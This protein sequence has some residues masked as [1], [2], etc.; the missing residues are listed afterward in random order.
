[1]VKLRKGVKRGLTIA[2]S[3]AMVVQGTQY[4]V[5][6]NAYKV[7]AAETAY[8]TCGFDNYTGAVS[9]ND[10]MMLAGEAAFTS[11]T[12]WGTDS[13]GF[14][15][16]TDNL[17]AITLEK[18]ATMKVDVILPADAAFQ[19][20]LKVQGVAQIGDS[21]VWTQCDLIPE[22]T[23]D[24]FT[25]MGDGYCKATVTFPFSQAT[26]YGADEAVSYADY[27][28][29]QNI[30]KV[31]LNFIG[32]ACDLNS[33]LYID[34]L[35]FS[36]EVTQ[37][38]D[39][40]FTYNFDGYDGAS[41]VAGD[42]ALSA[43]AAFTS[44]T[45]WGVDQISHELSTP[46]AGVTL[47]KGSDYTFDVIVPA[48]AAFEGVI[49]AQG[50]FKLGDS[51]MWTQCDVIPEL[52]WSS[53]T[54]MGNG[55]CKATVTFPFSQATCYGADGSC[56][57]ADYDGSMEIKSAVINLIGYACNLNGTVAIDNLA[58]TAESQPEVP[59]VEDF[60]LTMDDVSGFTAG[61]TSDAYCYTGTISL[62][63]RTIDGN[64]LLGV[65]LDYR[66]NV[67]ESWSEPKIFYNFSSPLDMTG[68]NQI[69]MDVYYDEAAKTTGSMAI[70]LFASCSNGESID[71]NAKI[72]DTGVIVNGFKKG[73][74]TI[75][76]VGTEGTISNFVLGIVGQSTDYYGSVLLDNIT[77]KQTKESDGY[78]DATLTARTDEAAV[79]VTANTVT[80]NGETV[81]VSPSV[82][83]ADDKAEDYVAQL[84]AY[85]QAYGD[86]S[87]VM[88][89]HQNDTNNKAGTKGA[90]FTSSDVKDIT[91]SISGVV[92]V[93]ALSLTGAELGSWDM[94]QSERVALCA[95]STREAVNQGAIITLSAHMPNF[96]LIKDRVENHVEGSTN[97]NEVGYLSDGSYNLSG[98]SPNTLTGNVVEN[99]MPGGEYN[100]YYTAYLDLIAE[101]AQEL[102]KDDIAVLFRPFHENTGAWFWWGS[103]S[104][105]EEAYKQLYRY[106]VDYLRDTKEVHNFLYVYGPS[107]EAQSTAEYEARYPGDD[108]V[109][110][111][112]FDMYHQNPTMDDSYFANFANELDIVET[113]A[114]AHNKL[115]A[116]TET[117]VANGEGTALLKSGNQVMD[118]YQKVLA[119]VKDTKASYFL[120]WANFGVNSGFYT[121]FVVSKDGDTLHGHEML[122][123]F[124]DFYNQDS[125]VFAKQTGDYK[126]IETSIE[127]DDVSGYIISPYSGNNVDDI[128]GTTGYELK[129][130]IDAAFTGVPAATDVQFKITADNTDDIIVNAG[131]DVLTQLSAETGLYETTD[132]TVNVSYQLPAEVIAQMPHALGTIELLVK[133]EVVSVVNAKFNMPEI[134]ESPLSVDSFESYYGYNEQMKSVWTPQKGAGNVSN[135]ILTSEAGTFKESDG[136]FG[137]AF[138]Y[139]LVENG[140]AGMTRTLG[141]SWADANAIQFWTLPDGK[142]QKTVIQITSGGNVFEVY[143]NLYD[144]YKDCTSPILVTIPFSEFV[145]RDDKNAVFDPSS[146]DGFGLWVNAV[147]N[148]NITFPLQSTI[149]Y[150]DITAV[151]TDVTEITFDIQKPKFTISASYSSD[152]GDGCV[153]SV[154]ITNVSGEDITN[155]WT[156]AFDYNRQISG[157]WCAN[158]VSQ[159]ASHYVISNPDWNK[160][161]RDGESVTFGFQ[162]G[163]GTAN[164]PILN[165]VVAA[166]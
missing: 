142:N 31:V 6:K 108:Y 34:D 47:K 90:D 109:D 61:S 37:E 26:C 127:Q 66:E 136:E 49:K 60:V 24:S 41:E 165:A 135:P 144:E 123:S 160:V 20:T 75:D 97:Q 54:D 126:Q 68:Y 10:N 71:Q 148:E 14:S 154:T 105:D 152:W 106:T 76:L 101:Y 141:T 145:G 82:N 69:V 120:V 158:L 164:E 33:N 39:T 107:S 121:P 96:K 146:I 78:V 18:N 95:Q 27:T 137:I 140:Y 118:W 102:A 35:E 32:Y 25:D 74:V 79:Q 94:T 51:W 63:P 2:L 103:S 28:G 161:I 117:G 21:W 99:I 13:V 147:P 55:Y 8:Y 163:A 58:L 119:A 83:L 143:L 64:N 115:F 151:N 114:V 139:T 11:S 72:E 156:A 138:N 116:V 110:M 122:D 48:D 80:A 70:K 22:L 36:A 133:G 112:G 153:V 65:A 62:D 149:Y 159:D 93:D 86:T 157:I 42:M 166:K 19:G 124:I 98:Y 131:A 130:H 53:F 57:I 5:W 23:W 77:F 155:G 30:Q 129:A 43:D 45:D 104:C 4:A 85:L 1:M 29:G 59:E 150:D 128:D 38:A 7:L 134:V 56:S 40:Y 46:F 67:T 100:K 12:E 52:S 89:G 9:V 17:G 113:F 44:A 16:S 125:T 111:V 91:G 162:A 73:K 81:S 132:E 88:F 15:L 87:S 92:G 50:V 84:Y 3:T